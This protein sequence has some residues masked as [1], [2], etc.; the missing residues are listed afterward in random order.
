MDIR[1]FMMQCRGLQLE[2]EMKTLYLY[3]PNDTYRSVIAGVT[4]SKELKMLTWTNLFYLWRW[5]KLSEKDCLKEA[6]FFVVFLICRKCLGSD[7]TC[8]FSR[9]KDNYYSWCTWTISGADSSHS[10][11]NVNAKRISR[12]SSFFLVKTPLRCCLSPPLNQ[13]IWNYMYYSTQGLNSR[14]AGNWI[15]WTNPYNN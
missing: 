6:F 7:I 5:Y 3:R 4:L 11:V 13:S 8:T 15:H 9:C 10:A 1:S 12:I 14:T 2:P